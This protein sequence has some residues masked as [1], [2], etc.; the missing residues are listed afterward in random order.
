[1]TFLTSVIG[2]ARARCRAISGAWLDL[3]FQRIIE[4][5]NPTPSFTSSSSY[6]DPPMNF[7]LLVFLMVLFG[8][9]GWWAW[10]GRN[11]CA[12]A[13]MNMSA[14]PCAGR[15]QL[16]D[17]VPPH[18][19]QRDG[20][21]ADLPALH[22]DRHDRVAGLARFPGL[23][24][25]VLGPVAGRDDACR[26]R[27]TC[28]APWLGFTAFFTFAIMLSL[29]VFVFEGIRDAFDPRKT[30]TVGAMT[31][32]SDLDGRTCVRSFRKDGASA[33]RAVRGVSFDRRQ[34]G[35][36]SR[37]WANPARANRSRRSPPCRCCPTAA[38]VGVHD[39]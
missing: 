37:W 3:I 6:R 25:A 22:R 23:R 27:T 28:N 39:L 31:C 29:L 1:V 33:D 26:P 16:D 38:E 20:G 7:W 4:I 8:W 5:W 30:F 14:R 11:S 10:C 24:P 21:D 12:R 2:I 35:R 19:A 32:R 36:P 18:A 9:T 13:T 17:H 34:A 15:G